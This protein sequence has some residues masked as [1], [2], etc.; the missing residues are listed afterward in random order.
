VATMQ[1]DE[2]QTGRAA[3][4]AD[5]KAREFLRNA[6]HVM[7]RLIDARPD[8]RPRA[9]MDEHSPVP[10]SRVLPCGLWRLIQDDRWGVSAI[11]GRSGHTWV[12]DRFSDS[13]FASRRGR[14]LRGWKSTSK[15]HFDDYRIA[16]AGRHSIV[17]SGTGQPLSSSVSGAR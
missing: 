8:F 1:K 15:R 4:V 2:R 13:S 16:M 5:A 17:G 11:E 7:A 10:P 14:L 9:W 12:A 6:D 3:A